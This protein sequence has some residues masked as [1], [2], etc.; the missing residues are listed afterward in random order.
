MMDHFDTNRTT[1]VTDTS[2]TFNVAL[3]GPDLNYAMSPKS[4]V[5]DKTTGA[6]KRK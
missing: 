2:N 4:V 3:T 1:S 5:L 6:S